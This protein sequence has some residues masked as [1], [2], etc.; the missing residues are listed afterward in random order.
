MIPFLW[1]QGGGAQETFSW[2]NSSVSSTTINRGG[3]DG[4]TVKIWLNATSLYTC[5]P[6]WSVWR[7]IDSDDMLKPFEFLA[8]IDILYLVNGIRESIVISFTDTDKLKSDKLLG[9]QF[10]TGNTCT[11]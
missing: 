8:Y 6:A 2:W 11:I 7:W 3:E 9:E 5:L 4:A 1:S 10:G